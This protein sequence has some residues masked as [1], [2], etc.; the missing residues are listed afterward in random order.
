MAAF[1]RAHPHLELR[2]NVSNRD[3]TVDILRDYA[4]DLAIMGRP[5]RDF[6]VEATPFGFHPLVVIAPPDHR[7]ARHRG[8][9]RV[10]LQSERFLIREIGSGTRTAF[11]ATFAGFTSD[12]RP[13]ME[14]S[15]NET[16]KQAVMAGLGVAL[17]SG[18]TVAAELADGRLVALDIVG[19][20]IMRHWF[21]VRRADRTLSSAAA[22]FF[23]FLR[24]SGAAFLPP[25]G[26]FSGT[27][28]PAG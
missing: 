4:V 2:L 18:H 25:P 27:E 12:S 9:P 26:L 15:S 5:P 7:L 22:A 11:E 20:P 17:I 24:D 10:A 6:E 19:L 8:I 13:G 3:G 23:A 16:I 21:V 28:Q 14:M 1:M